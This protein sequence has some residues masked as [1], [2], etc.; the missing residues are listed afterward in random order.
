MDDWAKELVL[1]KELRKIDIRQPENF[2]LEK[3][4]K[5]LKKVFPKKNHL[6]YR[7]CLSKKEI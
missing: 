4:L 3:N 5:N 1:K 2:I 6:F 7:Y